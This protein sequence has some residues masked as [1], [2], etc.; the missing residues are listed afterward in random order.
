M[1]IAPFPPGFELQPRKGSKLMNRILLIDRDRALGASLGVAC[2]E[3]GIAIRMAETFCEGVRYLMDFPITAVLVDGAVLEAA[4]VDRGRIFETVAPG[5]PVVVV[6]SRGTPVEQQV[7]FEL[8]GFRVLV[9]PFASE[10][11]L[12]KLEWAERSTAS[13]RD[14]AAQVRAIC[15]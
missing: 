7:K 1:E 11:V 15:G 9:K 2:L 6:V 3:R 12:D 10:E 5:V 4:G 13:G 14:A 8:Q